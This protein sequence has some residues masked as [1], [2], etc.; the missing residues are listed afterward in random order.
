MFIRF[1]V[2]DV[3]K[4]SE[5]RLGVFQ[6]VSYLKEGNIFFDYELDHAEYLLDWFN[7]NLESPFDHLNKQ[8]LKKSDVYISWFKISAIEHI[9]KVRELVSMLENRDI[10]VDQVRAINPGKIVYQDNFQVFAKPFKKF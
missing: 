2:D 1:V 6:A 5:Q 4:D 3:C 7:K 10:F 8:K 9:A